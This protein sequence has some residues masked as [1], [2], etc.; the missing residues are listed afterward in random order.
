MSSA[1]ESIVWDNIIKKEAR[2]A[3][4]DSDFGEIQQV[5]YSYAY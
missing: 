3:A 5:G 2:G 1:N 4:D